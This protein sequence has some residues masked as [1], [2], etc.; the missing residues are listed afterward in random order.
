MKPPTYMS[1]HTFINVWKRFPKKTL[2]ILVGL[3]VFFSTFDLTMGQDKSE[4][5]D[6]DLFAQVTSAKNKSDDSLLSVRF[7]NYTIQE[8]LEVLAKKVKVGFSYNPKIIPE[9][10]VTLEMNDVQAY[11]IL[12]KLLEG[13]NL[14]P[15]LP[16]TKDVIVIR[17]KESLLEVISVVQNITGIVVDA[18]TGEALTG[19]TV[20]VEGSTNSN[21]I[22]TTTNLDGYYEIEVPDASNTLIFSYVGYQ[23]L[24]VAIDGRAEINVELEQDLLLMNEMVVVGYGIQEARDVTGSVSKVNAGELEQVPVANFEQALKGR[25][26]GVNVSQNTGEP[27]GRTQIRIRGGNSMIG[28]NNPLYVV[29]GFPVTTGIDHLSPSDIESIDI[30]KD[31]SATAIYGARGANGVV[32]V[33]TKTGSK[34]QAG[35]ITIHSYAGVQKESNRVEMMNAF[36][37]ATLVNDF[38]GNGGQDPY[39]QINAG[40]STITDGLGN[41]S[42]F[43]GTNWQDV[44]VRDALIQSHSVTFSGGSDATTYSLSFNYLDQ[45]GILINSGSKKGNL[46]LHL[47][48]NVNDWIDLAAVVNMGRNQ[49]SR[50]NVNNRTLFD[51][52]GLAAPPTVPIYREDGLPTRLFDVYFFGS[53]DMQNPLFNAS[54]YKDQSIGDNLLANATID[55]KLSD[56]LILRSLVGLESRSSKAETFIPIIYPG[57]QASASESNS[58][59]SSFLT[60]NTLNYNV[61][62]AENHK[63]SMVGGITYQFFRNR[64]VDVS[65]SDLPG[66][67]TRNF[68]L[69]SAGVIAPPVS[70]L[71]EWKLLSG[72]GRVNYSYNDKYLMTVSLRADGSSRFGETNKWGLFPSAAIGWRISNEPFMEGVDLINDLKLRASYGVTGNTALSPYQS[73]S[74]MAS[75]RVIF[76]GNSEVVAFSTENIE[77]PNLKWE[78]TTQIDAGFDLSMWE[79]ALSFTFDYYRKVTSN[80]LASVPLPTSSGYESVLRNIGEIQNSG[81]EF[82]INA[83]A[84]RRR[85]F[86]WDIA[87]HISRN[88]NEVAEIAGGSDI[89]GSSLGLPFGDTSNIAR[90]GEVFGA[91]YG[92][93]EEPI[94]PVTGMRVRRDINGD[95]SITADDRVIL[96]SPYPDFNIGLTNDFFYKNFSLNVFVNGSFGHEIFWAEAGPY[97]NSFQRGSNQL[98][99]VYGNY[100][101]PENPNNAK[102]PKP[103]TEVTAIV[104]DKLLFD[105]SYLRVS[106]VTLAYNIPVGGISWFN[107]AQIYVSGHNLLT[108]TNYPGRDPDVNSYGTDSQNVSDRLR[109]GVNGSSYPVARSFMIGTRLEF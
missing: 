43:D 93:I 61:N 68:A 51:A 28:D 97:T 80:L 18:R 6:G 48:H 98:A 34:E 29:D 15:V 37:Y 33:T 67:I 90:E 14:E 103:S 8:A 42:T 13:T 26:S 69:G 107:R 82:S 96:G 41:V 79:G 106:N 85:D 81:V 105:G 53:E 76:E 75:S 35:T 16:P 52:M 109:V 5:V 50:V 39:F 30:L 40:A 24:E 60:E 23:G 100:W 11:E 27:G 10:R 101:T 57:D 2:I 47:N 54:P 83:H 91:F 70:G 20:I 99:D 74:R 86:R 64:F 77:N 21:P 56:G 1:T 87:G 65:V 12:Y 45:E 55:F 22:G 36:E 88:V 19:V 104:S 84:V 63:L 62:F 44:A 46:R 9:K 89:L 78:T 17:E 25:A 95:G 73:L 4:L 49:T 7:S 108:I 38:L 102:Y 3:I 66:N 92:Y 31:A 71:S 32:I 59:S 58:K 94:D 72:L